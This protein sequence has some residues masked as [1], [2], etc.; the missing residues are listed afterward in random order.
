M[1]WIPEILQ[2]EFMQNALY[3]SLLI[4]LCCG[5]IGSLCVVNRMV[6]LAGGLAH[7]AYGGVGIAIFFGLPILLGASIFALAL[8]LLLSYFAFYGNRSDALIGVIWALG[9]ALGILFIDL[10][11]GYSQDFMSYLFGS[12][13]AISREDLYWA[14]G[15]DVVLIVFVGLYYREIVGISYDASFSKLKRLFTFLLLSAILSL[16]ALGIMI[17]MQMV[18]LI[19]IIALMSIPAYI[20]E[21][22]ASS[23]LEMF[24]WA[25]F[26]AL[27]FI[28]F[29]VL[30]SYF[31]DLPAGAAIVLVASLFFFSSMLVQFLWRRSH[32]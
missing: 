29:G 32:G 8:A 2:Y 12:I 5:I 22:I 15:Y 31:F 7:G 3:A 10:T 14:L 28:L 16:I 24:Y 4:A 13:T 30:L 19:L 21:K 27:L 25:S 11:P 23:L 6:F 1:D 18:G 9:M 20:A 26:F 17:S